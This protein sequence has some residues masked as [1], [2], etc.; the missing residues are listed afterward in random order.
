MSLMGRHLVVWM[1]WVMTMVES[2]CMLRRE[3]IVMMLH[4]WVASAVW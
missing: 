3:A 4:H 2:R 1:L